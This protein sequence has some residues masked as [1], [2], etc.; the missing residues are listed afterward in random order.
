MTETAHI[1]HAFLGFTSTRLSSEV[2]CPRTLPR[3]NPEDPVQLEPRTPRLQVKDFATEPRWT[4]TDLEQS[5]DM[6]KNLPRATSRVCET[7]I[8]M[9]PFFQKCNLYIWPWT[10]LITLTLV[11]KE[12]LIPQGIHMQST[13]TQ[14]LTIQK[15]WPILKFFVHKQKNIQTGQKLYAPDISI[16]E[17]NPF[18]HNDTFWRPWE[19][20]LWK[21]LM[22]KEKLLVTSNFSFS[23]SVFY[24]F[25]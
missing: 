2:L 5:L 1:I 17:L 9:T 6:Q 8:S 25:E 7:L 19:I 10:W 24:R 3:K 22:E 23:H 14:S 13:T 18:P 4:L 15:L 21:T 16:W 20:S 12:S 11:P